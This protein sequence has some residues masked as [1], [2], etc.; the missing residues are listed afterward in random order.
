[1][2]WQQFL[3]R[4]DLKDHRLSH[5]QIKPQ[6][7]LERFPV[8]IERYL[9]LSLDFQSPSFSTHAKDIPRKPA[10]VAPAPIENVH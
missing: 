3:H 2:D 10:Q 8:I 7:R 4:L 9:N 6:T 5:Q 1:M